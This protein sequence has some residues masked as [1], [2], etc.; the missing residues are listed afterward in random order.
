[1]EEK[2][3]NRG[4]LCQYMT[5]TADLHL[6]NGSTLL[7]GTQGEV[8]SRGLD[9]VYFEA[10]LEGWNFVKVLILSAKGWTCDACPYGGFSSCPQAFQP[11]QEGGPMAFQLNPK[12]DIE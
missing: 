3:E 7:N 4:L 10:E 1:M 9:W 12:G 8:I 11:Q 6:T 2:H 5:L